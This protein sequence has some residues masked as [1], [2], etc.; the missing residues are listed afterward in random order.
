MVSAEKS[1]HT[2]NPNKVEHL[3]N[4]TSVLTLMCRGETH[5]CYIDTIDY[6]LV[7]GYRWFAYEDNRVFYARASAVSAAGHT[8]TML[9][10]RLIASV[11]K[12]K[13][14]DHNDDNGLNNCRL[15]LYIV[16]TPQNVRRA[17][18]RIDSPTSRFKGVWKNKGKYSAQIVVQRKN[19]WL[20]SFSN[21]TDAA[22]AYDAAALKYFGEFAHL[23][24]RSPVCWLRSSLQHQFQI[25]EK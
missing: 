4:G 11:P 2:T 20:G 7:S 10:H 3:P 16:T 6:P 8:R 23:N 14:T 25:K 17:R 5:V 13:V 12:G 9:M 21:E 22:R 19:T 1:F 15:N 18:K 24:F